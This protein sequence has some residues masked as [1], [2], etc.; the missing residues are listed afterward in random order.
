MID[1]GIFLGRNPSNGNSFTRQEIIG[2]MDRYGIERALVAPYKSIFFDFKEGNDDLL[3]FYKSHPQRI[4]PAAF[5]QP[6]GFDWIKD[7]DY[8][9]DLERRGARVLGI[10]LAPKYYDIQ[11]ESFLLRNLA[12]KAAAEGLVLQFGLQSVTDLYKVVD[13]Y[14]DLKTPILIRWMSGRGYHSLAE[15]LNIAG[16]HK[17]F[18]FDVGSLTCAGGIKHLAESIGANRLYF[19][20]NGPEGFGLS[21][22]LL[23]QSSGLEPNELAQIYSGTLAKIFS[24]HSKKSERFNLEPWNQHFETVLKKPKID[25]HWHTDGWNIIEPEKSSFDDFRRVF[26]QFNYKKVVLSSIRA[27]NDDFV[28]GN[29]EIFEWV[30]TDLRLYGLIVIDPTRIPD[31][32]EQIETHASHRK[33]VGIKTIQDLYNR[34][35]DHP[36][37]EAI[38]EKAQEKGLSVM[39]H[40]P[41]LGEAARRFPNLPFIC[42]HST[43]ERVRH[44]FGIPNIYFDIATS[45]NNFAETNFEAFI[46]S[47][48]EDKILFASDAPLVHPAWTLGKLAST[49]FS[50]TLLD[51]ILFENAKQ[52][53]PKL[54]LA[55]ELAQPASKERF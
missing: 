20:S 32:L 28:E 15:I 34:K 52:A 55:L 40:I 21:S 37:Y 14:K 30:N 5:I 7:S 45:H 29:K 27:L 24:L 44:L 49:K 39:A 31:S 48:G 26:N 23:L 4:I 6:Y 22:H 1:G 17:N 13:Y 36:S 18:Y 3:D 9:K 50:S 11:L 53:F 38:L 43:Y 46:E 42:A 33:C 25:T 10:Y 8:L 12:K 19:T 54:A 51:K 2:W 35:L 41:G 16:P 47:A